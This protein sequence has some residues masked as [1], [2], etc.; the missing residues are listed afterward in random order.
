MLAKMTQ[1]TTIANYQKA[2]ENLSNEEIEKMKVDAK[3]YNESLYNSHITDPYVN[4]KKLAKRYKQL[5]NIDNVMGYIEIPKIKVYLPIYH[6]SSKKVLEKGVGHLA[7]TSLPIGGKSTHSVLTGHRGLPSA[8]LFTNID[9]LDQGDVFYL[10]IFND[11]LAY[12][13]DQIKVVNPEDSQDLSIIQGEDY[14]TLITC[15]PYG[16][17]THRLLV[18]GTRIPYVTK[19]EH[20]QK[21]IDLVSEVVIVPTGVVIMI[22]LPVVLLVRKKRRGRHA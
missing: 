22:V 1:S 12:K 3:E 7:N 19:E 20:I 17:N 18:R 5:L 2:V 8:T 15:T 11:V 16:I 4:N 10:H 21:Q 6:G 14:V 13:V 9:Q